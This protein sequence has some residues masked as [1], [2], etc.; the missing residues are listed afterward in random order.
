MRPRRELMRRRYCSPRLLFTAA[1]LGLAGC[2]TS[3]DGRITARNAPKL[4]RWTA[5][6]HIV[7]VLDLSSPR[8]DGTLA[9]ATAGR[10][11]LLHPTGNATRFATGPGGY[12]SPGGGEPYIAL[13]PGETVRGARCTFGH[14]TLYALR[15]VHGPGVTA[16]DATGR[17]R[18]FASLPGRGLENGIAFDRTGR[19]GHR[20]LV[21]ATAGSKTTIYAIDCR[22]AVTLV[23]HNAP[24]VEGGVAVAPSTFGRFAGDLIAPD[25]ISGQI[26]AIAPDGSS[27][28]VADSGL[29]HGQDVGAESLEFVPARFRAGGSVLVADRLTPGNAHPGDDVVLRIAAAS[30]FNSGVRPGDLLITTEGGARTDAITCGSTCGVRHVADG[31]AAAHVEGH[32]V[33]REPT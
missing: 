33:F 5:A 27:R 31:P 24:R 7:G 20:L 15:V 30:L 13:S 28:L 25:E 19:F 8:S 1:A 18:R 32:V 9:V 23:T 29:P 14:D 22:G 2:G 4:A 6:S 3:A 17:A 12:S 16:I 21:T 11:A 10:L 26:F